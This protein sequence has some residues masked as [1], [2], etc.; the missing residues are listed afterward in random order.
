[1]M[2]S[3]WDPYRD[4]I[5]IINKHGKLLEVLCISR[6]RKILFT[7]STSGMISFPKTTIFQFGYSGTGPR[8]FTDFLRGAGFNVSLDTISSIKAPMKLK[9][10]GSKIKGETKK[11]P[12]WTKEFE[13]TSLEQVREQARKHTDGSTCIMSEEVLCDGDP[14]TIAETVNAGNL[15]KEEALEIAKSFV[16]NFSQL[17]DYT[18]EDKK[19]TESGTIHAFDENEATTKA[20][21]KIKSKEDSYKSLSHISCITETVKLH[22]SNCDITRFE[23]HYEI[24]GEWV[25]WEDGSAIR[26]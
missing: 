20:K 2:H 12:Q 26:L 8:F 13:G 7:F 18:I 11:N 6:G 24:E 21:G 16:P 4:G 19:L 10:D 25:V 17:I 23:K 5:E 9:P 1:M 15:T 14:V 3:E 22:C